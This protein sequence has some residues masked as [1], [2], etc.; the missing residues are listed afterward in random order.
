MK[1]EDSFFYYA[2]NNSVYGVKISEQDIKHIYRLCMKAYPYE[3]GGI[4][5]GRYSEDQKWAEISS[6]TAPPKGSKHT[7][8]NFIR[9]GKGIITLLDRLWNKHIYYLGEWHYHPGCSPQPSA[10]DRST[11]F[12]LSKRKELH[13]PEPLLLIIGGGEPFWE[14]YLSVFANDNEIELHKLISPV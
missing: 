11:M 13:C 3:T 8:S 5:I 6:I 14:E 12:M 10:I 7:R 4:L 1:K 9:N 2:D